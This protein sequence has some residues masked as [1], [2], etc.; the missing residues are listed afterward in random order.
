MLFQPDVLSLEANAAEVAQW[1]EHNRFSYYSRVFQNFS[2][3]SFTPVEVPIQCRV[4]VYQCQGAWYLSCLM[5]KPTKWHVRQAKT[6]QTGRIICAVWS[7]SLLS[8]WR[9]LGSLSTHWEH[10]KDAD[11]TGRMP[12]LIWVFAGRTCHFVGF[13]M[14]WAQWGIVQICVMV[15]QRLLCLQQCQDWWGVFF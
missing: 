12:R 7:E 10:S 6:P 2:G 3:L 15:G 4:E 1:L 11:Q 9:K 14:S 8:A 5:T 13:V